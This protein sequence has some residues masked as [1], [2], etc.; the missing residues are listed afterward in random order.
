[1]NN[2]ICLWAPKDKREAGNNKVVKQKYFW[3]SKG[4]GKKEVVDGG[5]IMCN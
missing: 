3:R 4:N 5:S 2:Q 1:M